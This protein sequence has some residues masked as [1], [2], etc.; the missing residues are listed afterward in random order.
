[1]CL[2]S[3]VT[4]EPVQERFDRGHQQWCRL[5]RR[6]AGQWSQTKFLSLADELFGNPRPIHSSQLSGWRIGTLRDPGPKSL[7][8]VGLF[9]LALARS[10]GW[11]PPPALEE[12]TG[13]F[14]GNSRPL[15]EGRWHMTY[16]D[17]PLGPTEV[18]QAL[19]GLINLE[20]SPPWSIS[21][22]QAP[23]IQEALGPI[24]RTLL[25]AARV[26]WFGQLE[27]LEELHQAFKPV[28]LGSGQAT[29]RQLTE[30]LPVLAE[31]AHIAPEEVWALVQAGTVD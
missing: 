11:A 25:A 29:G 17:E 2:L 3:Y 19:A 7:L 21:D 13:R 20:D 16:Q 14:S 9:N 31:Q 27:T 12:I 4:M 8:A 10:N 26:D 6:W 5:W 24:A 1:M 18:F 23:A 22:T 30:F 15:W 28:L